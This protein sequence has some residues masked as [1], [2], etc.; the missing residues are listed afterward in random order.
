MVD[1]KYKFLQNIDNLGDNDIPEIRQWL[2]NN[3]INKRLYDGAGHTLLEYAVMSGSAEVVEFLVKNGA[4][5]YY[6]TGEDWDS[7][8]ELAALVGNLDLI[9]YFLGNG[10][11]KNVFL[12]DGSLISAAVNN[13]AK[14]VEYLINNGKNID[15]HDRFGSMTALC[16]A[17]QMHCV[18]CVKLLCDMG[19]DIEAE[20]KYGTPLFAAASSGDLK[21][22]KILLKH[23]ANVNYVTKDGSTPYEI[24]EYNGYNDVAEYLLKCGA[25]PDL[26]FIKRGGRIPS[27]WYAHTNKND[28]YEAAKNDGGG[29][30]PT[31]CEGELQ[32][33]KIHY[34]NF[35]RENE[36][37][38][39]K[40]LK[41]HNIY[42]P[43]K[44]CK[45]TWFEYAVLND[46]T[47]EM[48]K[49]LLSIGISTYTS[50]SDEWDTLIEFAAMYGR[51][52]II[53]HLLENGYDK[54]VFLQD[55]SLIFAASNDFTDVIRYLIE[56]GKEIDKPFGKRIGYTALREVA[57]VGNL[58]SARLLCELG[59][60]VNIEG[61]DTP[62]YSASA[63]GN[64]EIVKLLVNNGAN[65]NYKNRYGVTPYE[66]AKF[67]N[68]AEIADYLLE[69]SVNPNV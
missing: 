69:R 47:T 30:E 25:D 43:D 64:F 44:D 14:I 18:E 7:I 49:F 29:N 23:G 26:A 33:D 66:I 3:D 27:V 38:V 11:D 59:A 1:R 28:A 32:E 8:I 36:S 40:W 22:V 39:N 50:S 55:N 6:C 58:E 63:E 5:I 37:V 16:M 45:L 46:Y 12:E 17:S 54:K 13:H 68:H 10:F 67:S 65:V 4:G 15:R 41:N 21:I 35:K 24:A 53:K 62:L 60:N 9:K 31:F 34:K 2:K 51:L 19:A 48:V 61:E 52:D 56:N 20:S 42:L 57:Q